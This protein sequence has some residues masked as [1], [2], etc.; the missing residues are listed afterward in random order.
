M[1]PTVCDLC[2]RHCGADRNTSI[3]FCGGSSL[4]KVARAALHF[5]EEPV[6]S[7]EEGSGTVFFSGC[8]LQCVFC[9]NH[10]ISSGNFGQEISIERLSQIFLELQEQGA[11]NIN[12]VTGTHYVPQ[13]ITA[14]DLV[15]EQLHI[16]VVYNSSGYE[17]I[18]TLR[19]LEGYVDVYL[20]DLKYMDSRRSAHYSNAPDYPEKATAAILDMFRQ[21]GPVQ[22]DERGLLKKGLVLR[23]MVMPGGVEDSA[24][25]LRWAA[26]HLPLDDI[27]I[28]IMSQYTPFH[29]SEEFPEIHRR[30]TEEE[31]DAVLDV[32]DEL[33]IENGFCQELSSASEEY[34]PS[35]RL[36]GVLKKEGNP[37]KATIQ[38][39]I[40][41]F[42]DDYCTK[43]G[44]QRIWQPALVGIA[45]ASDPGFPEL[46]KLVI[47]DH[48][49][50][51]E[52]LPSA[53]TVISYFLPFI[54]EVPNSNIG[55]IAPSEPWAL[56]YEYT[57]KMAADLNTHLIE[58]LRD[59]G[60]EGAL[61]QAAML[62]EPYL[63]SRWSQRHV[64]KIAGLGTFGINNMLIT[65]KGC[66]GRAYSIVTSMPLPVDKAMEEEACLYKR[67]GSCLLCVKRC[68]I[69]ALTPEGFD[70]LK[71]H[72][73]LESNGE[74]TSNGATVC[75]KCLVGMP[76]SFRR[77]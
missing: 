34:T 65:E 53:K 69:G 63:R 10:E 58:W 3:G 13:I 35:F 38:Q 60:Y 55:E 41:R 9:Q 73:H 26:K 37:V 44:W 54:P 74:K 36:E 40:D 18:E 28:S 77:P 64:A 39:V 31:Y 46:R 59:Q 57:N 70:R 72:L 56:A 49:L 11:N 8:P 51:Q 68:P 22:Y 66:C 50:P 14:L 2:P 52:A 4:P 25:V 5:W 1:I 48:Q 7:G 76:C 6:I 23:H 20:P 45:D 47:E 29:R 15:R 75:G 27:L 42:I 61:P 12:L 21:V 71:C 24:A 62:G 43:M 33:E 19:L 17:T 16:P 30:L 67:S 32:L